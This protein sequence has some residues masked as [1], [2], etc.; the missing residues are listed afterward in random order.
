MACAVVVVVTSTGFDYISDS[1]F[2]MENYTRPG[3]S[4]IPAGEEL[5]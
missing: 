3:R 4:T 5:L 1:F 2:P